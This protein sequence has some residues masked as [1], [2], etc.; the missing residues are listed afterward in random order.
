MCINPTIIIIPP[1][2]P[3]SKRRTPLILFTQSRT[4]FRGPKI[5]KLH[6]SYQPCILTSLRAP[7]PLPLLFPSFP[8]LQRAG[9]EPL[10]PQ[11]KDKVKPTLSPPVSGI[12]LFKSFTLSWRLTAWYPNMAPATTAPLTRA[13]AANWAWEEV[14]TRPSQEDMVSFFSFSF[15][16]SLSTSSGWYASGRELRGSKW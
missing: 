10:Q 12:P 15:P 5:C 2:R 11:N 14:D 7:P 4:R 8:H 16:C 9:K 3:R 6:F 1:L 13:V